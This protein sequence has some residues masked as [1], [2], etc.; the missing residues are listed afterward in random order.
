M[1]ESAL[2]GT[3]KLPPQPDMLPEALRDRLGPV[4]SADREGWLLRAA[5]LELAWRQGGQMAIR[6]E[7]PVDAPA[8]PETAPYSPPEMLALWQRIR[9]LNEKW[10]ALERRWMARCAEQGW[11][12]PPAMLPDLLPFASMATGKKN[13][14]PPLDR[15]E[16][17][18][19]TL[20][21]LR[22]IGGARGRWLAQQWPEA[23]FLAPDYDARQWRE[24]NFEQRI[25]A[26]QR[27]RADAP[28]VA[29]QWIAGAWEQEPAD[30]KM[31]L[32]DVLCRDLTKEDAPFLEDAYQALLQTDNRRA[33]A[34][35]LKSRMVGALLGLPGHSLR[36][37]WEKQLA[38][39][40][41]K[42]RGGLRAIFGAAPPL[43]LQLPDA[44]DD[45]W[46]IEL[47]HAQAGL[48]AP[49]PNAPFA[50]TVRRWF[51]ELAAMVPPSLWR[52]AADTDAA[53]VIAFFR[54][55]RQFS[56]EMQ[57]TLL[58]NL[59][60]AAIDHRD[61]EYAG[62]LLAQLPDFPLLLSVAPLSAI[63]QH[64]MAETLDIGLHF[65]W[66]IAFSH[67][68]LS[69]LYESWGYRQFQRLRELWPFM[70]Y[71]HPDTDLAAV[72]K[73]FGDPQQRER[74]TGE[75]APE[76]ART[77]ALKRALADQ[78]AP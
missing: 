51:A 12:V 38:S 44:P 7:W 26:L 48:S 41:G 18:A 75:V 52:A 39:C 45:F 1:L 56:K 13:N 6:P 27:C 66:S 4:P 9:A 50:E 57:K 2:I 23:E 20:R 71:L 31:A 14:L 30:R 22:Q 11:V 69:R 53:G 77:L 17:A 8:L 24:G 43:A 21:H 16:A 74:W 70:V 10:P 76:L 36:D 63:E 58:K 55:D 54:D 42:R 19:L 34:Q 46:N 64:L 78:A 32:L 59:T 67:F 68:M 72:A 3:E 28:A 47:M 61:A 15:I 35:R 60:S 40:L 25:A 33:Q 49:Q 62:M 29:R 5:A 65:E 73:S 37:A